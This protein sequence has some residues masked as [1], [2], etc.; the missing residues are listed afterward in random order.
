MMSWRPFSLQLLLLLLFLSAEAQQLNASSGRSSVVPVSSTRQLFAGLSDPSVGVI[1]LA[2]SLVLNASEWS[3]TVIVNRSLLVTASAERIA[4]Q[5]YVLL[6]F[7][8]LAMLFSVAPGCTLRLVGLELFNH[9]DLVGPTFRPMRQS[10]GATLIIEQCLQRRVASIPLDAVVINSLAAPRPADQEGQTHVINVIS[11]FT[12]RTTRSVS[13][14]SAATAISVYDYAALLPPD[15]SL[16]F[17]NLFYGGY[18][19]IVV[20]SYYVAEHVVP[21][22]C[23]DKRPGSE[24]VTLLLAQLAGGKDG[25]LTVHSSNGS[26]T[27]KDGEFELALGAAEGEV[28]PGKAAQAE[29]PQAQQQHQA[30]DGG[31][32]GHSARLRPALASHL[33]SAQHDQAR[34]SGCDAAA[35]GDRGT[36]SGSARGEDGGMHD[37]EPADVE[38]PNSTGAVAAGAAVAPPQQPPDVVAELGRM[39]QELKA[40]VKDDVIKLE[41]VIGC[42]TFGTVYKGTWRGLPVA[43]K[44][45]VFTASTAS[46]RRALQEA[47]L[48]QSITHPNIAATY[49]S[50]LQPLGPISGTLAGGGSAETGREGTDK[51][52]QTAQ[53]PNEW[54]LYIVQEFADGGTLGNLYGNKDLWPRIGEPDLPAVLSL[55]LGIARAVA[56]LHSKRIIHGD[57]NPNNVLLKR[58]GGEPSGFAVKVGDFGLSVMLPEHRTHLSNLRQ[59]TMFYMCPA[60]VMKGQVGPSSDVFSLG[61][62]LWELY[63]GRRA[64]T[65]TDAGPRYCSIFP[66]F[67]P[68]CPPVYSAV[69]LH[70]LQRTPQHRPP[71]A[72]VVVR[73]ERLLRLLLTDRQ[74]G[75]DGP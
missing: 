5:T 33:H 62:M 43:V 53:L 51:A 71:A 47:A 35:K 32:H 16:A 45:L 8:N 37:A 56:Y 39:A 73:L 34:G 54:R 22:S 72:D 25:S 7:S 13:P 42:G 20:R 66:S 69:A 68:T 24:C 46:R 23:L 61:V 27:P 55:G 6:D 9:F 31:P 44:S 15:S 70:C 29:Q 11:N 64:G 30:E 58:D 60:V 67:P 63:H 40:N 74:Q 36:A 48:C 10:I 59:G 1:V 50:E 18:K 17:Q 41:T 26:I 38:R 28:G 75:A 52:A 19:Y 49:S 14:L 65:R 2:D 4:A 12:F 3:G 57:L 21:Q